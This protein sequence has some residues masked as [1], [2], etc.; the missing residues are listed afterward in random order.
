M[1]N[2][3]QNDNRPNR[4]TQKAMIGEHVLYDFTLCY[5]PQFAH[6]RMEVHGGCLTEPVANEFAFSSMV[7]D[8][9]ARCYDVDNKLEKNELYSVEYPRFIYALMERYAA[10]IHQAYQSNP[11]DGIRLMLDW[12]LKTREIIEENYQAIPTLYLASDIAIKK[13]LQ[14][15]RSKDTWPVKLNTYSLLYRYFRYRIEELLPEMP[16]SLANLIPYNM[17]IGEYD[18]LKEKYSG[19]FGLEYQKRAVVD[20]EDNKKRFFEVL[21]EQC[22]TFCLQM[23]ADN[24][25]MSADDIFRQCDG[26][27]TALFHSYFRDYIER[28]QAQSDIAT[29]IDAAILNWIVNTLR[30][31]FETYAANQEKVFRKCGR[32]QDVDIAAMRFY[33]DICERIILEIAHV[34]FQDFERIPLIKPQEELKELIESPETASLDETN[35]SKGA[36]MPAGFKT[37]NQN[38]STSV[39]VENNTG[40]II[41]GG[42]TPNKRDFCTEIREAFGKSYIKVFLIDDSMIEQAKTVV[43]ALNS[44]KNVNITTSSSSSHRGNTLTIYPKPMV[45]VKSCE[46]EVKKSLLGFFSGG[47]KGEMHPTNEAFFEEIAQKILGALDKAEATI[48]VCVAWFTNPQLRDKLLAKSKD[49]VEVRVIIYKDGVNHTKGVDLSSLNH[50]EYRGERGGVLHDKF[51]VIDNVHTINGSY[52]WTL[53]AEHKNDEDAAFHFEDYKFA[54]S[55]TKRFNQMWKRDE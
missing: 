47:T 50:K 18:I 27:M 43:G 46:E 31:I 51:C 9:F 33:L 45:D 28:L 55:Y 21:V 2:Q 16:D 13:D 40:T 10:H 4:M 30:D 41:I 6:L 42:E 7:R 12:L 25:L 5:L 52:N 44:V 3:K 29:D 49:G 26:P 20:V 14:N 32:T 19:K 23:T 11:R 22:T 24:P 15:C 36:T 39:Y 38:S 48:D 34:Y 8:M 1:N 53:N 35:V 37:T 17:W 54:S